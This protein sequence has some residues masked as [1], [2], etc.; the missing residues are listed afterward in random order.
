MTL[1]RGTRTLFL[2]DNVCDMPQIVESACMWNILLI[3]K[4]REIYISLSLT[5]V[6]SN[7]F[8]AIIL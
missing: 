2:E 1:R 5:C 4:N 7:C 8:I 3:C 6:Y